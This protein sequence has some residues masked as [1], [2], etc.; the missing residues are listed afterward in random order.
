MEEVLRTL[1]QSQPEAVP[2]VNDEQA[3]LESASVAGALQTGR[4]T[5]AG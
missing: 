4:D 5:V 2:F 1:E 3:Q